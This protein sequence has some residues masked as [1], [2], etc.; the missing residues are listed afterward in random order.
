MRGRQCSP[1]PGRSAPHQDHAQRAVLRR[2]KRPPVRQ[3]SASKFSPACEQRQAESEEHQRRGLRHGRRRD[4]CNCEAA[5]VLTR[6][7]LDGA[8]HVIGRAESKWYP[9]GWVRSEK[10]LERGL[11]RRRTVCRDQTRQC[12][13][14]RAGE[15]VGVGDGA[16][17][18]YNSAV[19][20]GIEYHHYAA[21]A[22]VQSHDGQLAGYK[23]GRDTSVSWD[24]LTKGEKTRG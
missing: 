1:F 2:A 22:A 20:R 19:H 24:S 6:G 17:A 18:A 14:G 15:K 7:K 21:R 16:T 5:A 3:N 11:A 12:G 23:T 13:L 10:I 4:G 8:S 9:I